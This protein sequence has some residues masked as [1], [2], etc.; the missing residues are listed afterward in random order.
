MTLE[1]LR[2]Q[3][4]EDGRPTVVGILD[5]A[6]AALPSGEMTD[7]INEAHAVDPVLAD[8]ITGIFLETLVG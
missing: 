8:E 4:L 5:R 6:I 7:V 2:Q 1:E 3:A